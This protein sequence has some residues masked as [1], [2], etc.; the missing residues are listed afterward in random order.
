MSEQEIGLITHYFGHISVAAV[1]ITDGELRVGDTV[2]IK[3]H[4]TDF[5][6]PVESLEIEHE[7]VEVARPGDDVAMKVKEHAREHDIVY[8]VTAD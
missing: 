7:S 5:T 4:T 8:K 6:Q 1:Q 2:H 3:G